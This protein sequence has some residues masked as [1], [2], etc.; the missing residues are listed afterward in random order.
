M[1]KANI[2]VVCI[3]L[4][5]A[6][7]S[8]SA[9][10][11]RL[12]HQ[13]DIHGTKVVFVYAGDLWMAQ[14]SGGEASRL[15]IH[16]GIEISPKFSPDGTWIAFSGQYDGNLDVFIVPVEGGEPKRLTYHPQGDVVLGWTPDGK[17]ILF[18]SSRSSF[19][20]F[21]R[22]FT[23]GLEGGFPEELPIPMAESGSYSS[24]AKK[25]AYNPISHFQKWRRYRGGSTAA[26]W[27]LNLSDFSYEEILHENASDIN[28]FWMG[29]TVYFLSDR[30]RTMDLYAY[31][32]Q[33][34]ELKHLVQNG[35]YDIENMDGD[36]KRLVYESFGDIYIYNPAD[37]ESQKL[38]ISVPSDFLYVRPHY[39]NV[40]REIRSFNLSPSG[41][42][43]VFEA[44]GEILT[45]P[46]KKGDIRNLTNS[47]GVMDRYPA[48]SPD[49]KYIAYF[50]DK[51]GEYSLHIVDQKGVEG[52][53][54]IALEKPSF[55]YNPTWSPDSKKIV[56]TDKHMNVWYLDV[57]SKKH[58]KVDTDLYSH[59]FRTLDPVWSPDSQWIAYVRKLENY[60]RAVFVYSLEQNKSYQ[61]TDGMGD[62]LNP[63][64]DPDGKYLYF[65]ASTNA[66]QSAGW[67]DLSAF[68][69]NIDMSIYLVVL[70]KDQPSPLAPESD[71]EEPKKE[72]PKEEKPKKEAKKPEKKEAEK[73]D[74]GFK[75]DLENIGQ[76]IIALP[77]PPKIYSQLRAIKGKLFFL[78]SASTTI[79]G[80]PVG[81]ITQ[82][83]FK[84]RKASPF[85]PGV[86]AYAVSADGKKLIYN[87]PGSWGIVDTAGKPKP[88]DGRL[89]LASMQIFVDPR[90]EWKQMLHEAWRINRDFFYDPGMHGVDWESMRER[91]MAFLPYVAHR[92]DLNFLISEMISELCVGHAYTGGGS[93]PE[94][95]RV[96]GGLLGAD[97]KIVENRYQIKKIFS[98]L[99]WNPNLRAPLTEPGIQVSEGDYIIKVNGREL[100]APTNIY[101]LFEQTARK[102]VVLTLSSSPDGKES[103][104]VT[105]VPVPSEFG[106][107]NMAWVEG[108]RK[109]VAKASGGKIGYVYLPDTGGG[110]YTYFNRYFFSQLNKEGLVI[111]ERFNGGGFVADYIIDYLDRPLLNYW[112]TR[113]GKPFATPFASV[114]GPKVMII[115]EYAGSGGDALPWMFRERKIGPLVGKRTWG[116]L[117]G[118][119]DYPVLMDGG[120]VTAPRLAIFSKDSQWIVENEG[121]A[122]DYPIEVIPVD[123]I[124]GKDSQLEKAIGLVMEALKTMTVPKPVRP[125]PA[126]RK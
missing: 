106:L 80:P 75:I 38:E 27:I 76:R 46:V 61:I 32:V 109:R 52:K 17:K 73:K 83:D 89:N 37:G 20:G 79:F 33:K 62:A 100:R 2:L 31:N 30:E 18:L 99:N 14:D 58:V 40:S 63:V 120:T 86:L 101:S 112:A 8:L 84:E 115:N 125:K 122:P 96:P 126:I 119:Y 48:W 85:L 118:I 102:Q 77:V 81:T 11:T 124:K 47:P 26:V 23:V 105:V 36:G 55:Y 93:F 114:L 67:L 91:Y 7:A 98:G 3:F 5:I 22:L 69:R 39:E 123:Y 10:T 21:N 43:A 60:F 53:K 25:I 87:S 49:G 6:S 74:N 88:G 50:S 54:K 97:Y 51:G 24:D 110:G 57:E 45:V 12:L 113:D 9:G 94:V 82:F 56:F 19:S 34:K 78:E 16:P 65:T 104:E 90:L 108:N 68:N 15:T 64:F 111:D 42:R 71:E 28:P 1:K 41:V 95:Q 117:I 92:S 59:P 13:P 44:H 4:L 29:E 66:G 116:G 103:R 35:E 121:V 107:R 70:Q 72:E